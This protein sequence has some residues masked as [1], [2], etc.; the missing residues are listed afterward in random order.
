MVFLELQREAWDSSPGTTG[1]SGSL[2]CCLRGV[3]SLFE[4]R[5]G[6][7][8]CSG[9]TTGESGLNLHGRWNVKVFLQVP[10]EVWVPSSCDGELSESLILFLGSHESFGAVRGLSG[11]VSS[12]CRG[13]GPHL[14]LRQETQGSSP[15]LT[16]I[17]GFLWRFHWGVRCCLV[18]RHG[19]L[20][21]SRGVKGESGLLLS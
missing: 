10:Q 3:N 15:V 6:V 7:R 11:F 1:N 4:L 5:G 16:W 18:L 19:T 12:C 17:L 13:L 20:L 9:V 8:D 2:S 14:E 21:P